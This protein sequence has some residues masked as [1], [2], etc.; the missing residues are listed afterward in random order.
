MIF[1]YTVKIKKILK[2]IFNLDKII[3]NFFFFYEKIL[4]FD[5]I[6]ENIESF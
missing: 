1:L 5:L 2:N 6:S 4:A 3:F